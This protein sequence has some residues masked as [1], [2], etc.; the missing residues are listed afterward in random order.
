ME[1]FNILLENRAVFRVSGLKCVD[2]LN[3][4]LTADLNKLVPNVITPCA[5]LSPQGRIF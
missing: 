2:F 3:N 1:T 5:L 4:I